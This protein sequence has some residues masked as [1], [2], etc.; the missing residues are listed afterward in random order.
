L[1]LPGLLGIDRSEEVFADRADLGH[2]TSALRNLVFVRGN[3]YAGSVPPIATTPAL[4]R[5][6]SHE[7]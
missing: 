2:S 6:P 5:T 3:N 4:R 1:G 7:L